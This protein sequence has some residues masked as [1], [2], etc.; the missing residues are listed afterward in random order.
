LHAGDRYTA[1]ASGMSRH[2]VLQHGRSGQTIENGEFW[3][4]AL[5]HGVSHE[6]VSQSVAS[7]RFSP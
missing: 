5:P 6:P 1:A 2:R 4:E 7:P 3:A